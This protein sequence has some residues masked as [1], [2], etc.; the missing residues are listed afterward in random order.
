ME[1]KFDRKGHDIEAD[2][3]LLWLCFRNDIALQE[4]P[5]APP[6]FLR[7]HSNSPFWADFELIGPFGGDPKNQPFGGRQRVD[8]QPRV[9]RSLT[10]LFFGSELFLASGG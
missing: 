6:F 3:R 9:S 5:A 10:G 2:D 7:D 8:G 1:I 4:A